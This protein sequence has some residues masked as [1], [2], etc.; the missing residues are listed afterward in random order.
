M[1]RTRNTSPGNR[2]DGAHFPVSVLFFAWVGAF[3]VAN[4]L[5]AVIFGASGAASGEEPIW[6]VGLVAVSL[7]APLL[8]VLV[9]LSRRMGSG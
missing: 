8:V 1:N 5:A 9:M 3:V 6:V 4:I 7:W 2:G